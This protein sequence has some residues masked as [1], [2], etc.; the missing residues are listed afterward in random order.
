MIQHFPSKQWRH[1]NVMCCPLGTVKNKYKSLKL[2]PHFEEC[3]PQAESVK[4]F[5]QYKGVY[6][7][8]LFGL[9]NDNT[10][11]ILAFIQIG[12]LD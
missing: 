11:G 2:W 10:G 7:I 4:L 6:H 1:K 12:I 3:S 8:Y 9:V 5:S